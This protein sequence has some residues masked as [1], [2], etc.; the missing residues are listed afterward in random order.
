MLCVSFCLALGKRCGELKRFILSQESDEKNARPVLKCYTVSYL[1][2][3]M[4][5][6]MG[7][8]IVFYSLW[9][10]G[11][12][13]YFV[14]TVSIVLIICMLYDLVLMNTDGDSIETLLSSKFL[15]AMVLVYVIVMGVIIY[16]I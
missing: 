14:W 12:N 9:T 3:Y 1:E 2:K 4:Y 7:L 5:L 13:S 6:S 10:L 8:G 11:K 15:S 16:C